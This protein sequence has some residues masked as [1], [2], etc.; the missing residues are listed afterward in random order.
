MT[1]KEKD[2]ARSY[3]EGYDAGFSDGVFAVSEQMEALFDLLE[4]RAK[5][6]ERRWKKELEK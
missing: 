2:L 5:E 3:H 1:K 4:D 6:Q